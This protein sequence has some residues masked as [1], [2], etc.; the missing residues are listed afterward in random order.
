MRDLLLNSLSSHSHKLVYFAHDL[1]SK[2]QKRES[3]KHA[4][5][6]SNCGQNGSEI[7]EDIF[8]VFLNLQMSEV[9]GQAGNVSRASDQEEP[10]G[11]ELIVPQFAGILAEVAA[12][13]NGRENAVVGRNDRL[14]AGTNGLVV[15]YPTI[16][17]QGGKIREQAGLAL[18]DHLLDY[19][20]VGESSCASSIT[21][22]FPRILYRALHCEFQIVFVSSLSY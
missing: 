10:S 9:E 3:Q 14:F 1:Q 18:S 12:I 8:L 5:G 17:N 22:S 11:G 2:F 21:G 4:H 13:E 6:A 16:L 19:A 20:F 7:K 15:F